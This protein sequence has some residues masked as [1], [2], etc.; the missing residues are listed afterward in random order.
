VSAPRAAP[1]PVL[2]AALDALD[3]VV[4]GRADATARRLELLMRRATERLGLPP[5][6]DL[7]CLEAH[8]PMAYWR[9][10][11]LPAP[12]WATEEGSRAELLVW[13]R[14]AWLPVARGGATFGAGF[15]F[16]AAPGPP[17]LAPGRAAWRERVAA[18][19]AYIGVDGEAVRCM[20][21]LSLGALVGQTADLDGRATALA[22]WARGAIDDIARLAPPDEAS[23]G[24][25]P[26]PRAQDRR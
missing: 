26:G 1:T 21:A 7:G 20:R 23:R 18:R 5:D 24:D 9:H 6:D 15:S 2:G 13:P 14:D 8:G 17:L 4:A 12:C 11:R 10:F 19:G 3:V 16:P 25:V 22:A